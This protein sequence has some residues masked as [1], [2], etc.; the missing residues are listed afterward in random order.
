MLK[1]SI[2]LSSLN[3]QAVLLWQAKNTVKTFSE[4]EIEF[5]FVINCLAC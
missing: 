3:F 5:R 1:L 2:V 4:A